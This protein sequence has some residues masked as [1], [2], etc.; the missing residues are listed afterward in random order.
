MSEI[1]NRDRSITLS[2]VVVRV[3]LALAV[4]AAVALPVAYRQNPALLTGT[5]SSL[6]YLGGPWFFVLVYALLI[7]GFIAVLA[8][9]RVLLNLAKGRVFT[10]DNVNALRLLSWM[11]FLLAGI[12]A[13]GTAG[14]TLSP[15]PVSG[16]LEIPGG[17]SEHCLIRAGNAGLFGFA[18]LTLFMA[19][20][21]L[22]V[23]VV[24]NVLDAGVVLKDEN[25]YTI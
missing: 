4:V 2:L 14:N 1:W 16:C 7:L 24:K 5:F 15:M 20:V 25:D 18:L 23:R 3:V 19:F 11:C 22:I 8:L 21:G 12:L 10:P 17:Y 6:F 13:A 9:H